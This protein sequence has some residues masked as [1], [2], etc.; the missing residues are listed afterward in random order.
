[1]APLNRDT[2]HSL[3]AST[4][5]GALCCHKRGIDD[6]VIPGI[7]NLPC[8]LEDG[9]AGRRAEHPLVFIVLN[10]GICLENDQPTV[11]D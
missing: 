7:R 4:S 3:S 1:M 5:S 2:F 8:T 6:R 11:Q 9:S 10:M